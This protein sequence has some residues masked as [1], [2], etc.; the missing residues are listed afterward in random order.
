MIFHFHLMTSFTTFPRVSNLMLSDLLLSDCSTA[1]I[2]WNSL[3]NLQRAALKVQ[4]NKNKKSKEK[5][6]SG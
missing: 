5:I 6:G 2:L 3:K 4:Q 1:F